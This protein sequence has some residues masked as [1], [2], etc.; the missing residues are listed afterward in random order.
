MID[1]IKIKITDEVLISKIWNN[2]L[3]EYD[4][5]AEKRFNDEIKEL[6]RK[7][8]KNIY[9]TKYH[10]RLE[11]SGSL[12]KFY[13]NE[14]HNANDFTFE[15]VKETIN[16][17]KEF[18]SLELEKCFIIN[19]E[20]GINIISPI[21]INNLVADL[22]YHDKRQFHRPK[23]YLY[24]KVAG[25]DAYKQI[26]AYN[27]FI[28]YPDYCNENTFRFEVKSKQSKFIN[29]YDILTLNDLFNS[30]IHK[31]LGYSLVQEWNRVLLFDKQK[32]VNEKYFNTNFWEKTI[33][34]K[35]RNQFNYHRK[36]Y[37]KQL[38]DN[39]LHSQILKLIQCKILQLI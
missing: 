17:I 23:E 33:T 1:F 27:K 37:F 21:P 29:K 3:L 5:K 18:F 8:Y 2:K 6:I 19:L 12:H 11:L 36:K 9:F 24:Y 31:I 4:S 30:Q 15:K 28:Q 16:Q 35:S 39:N 25:I 13:N 10:N 14:L 38:G 20:Y 32:N 26:K 34:I 7:K 22:I